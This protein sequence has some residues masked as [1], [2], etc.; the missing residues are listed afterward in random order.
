[1]QREPLNHSGA[2]GGVDERGVVRTY[3]ATIGR[4]I[5]GQVTPFNTEKE[6]AR[7]RESKL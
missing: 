5:R 4:L 1:M 3:K 2:N 6:A 7:R